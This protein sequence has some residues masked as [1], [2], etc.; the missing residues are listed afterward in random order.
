[1]TRDSSQVDAR[2]S[3]ADLNEIQL[4]EASTTHRL[5]AG[6]TADVLDEVDLLEK[7]SP[8]ANAPLLTK[9]ELW[10]GWYGYDWANR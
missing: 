2:E 4:T 6:E 3:E 9:R 1:M 5:A 7:S 10:L 8:G